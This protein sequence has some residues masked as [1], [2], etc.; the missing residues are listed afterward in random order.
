VTLLTPLLCALAVLVAGAGCGAFGYRLGAARAGALDGA[1]R[2]ATGA[3]PAAPVA[4]FLASLTEFGETVAPIWS[5]HVDASRQQMETAVGDLVGTFAGIVSLLDTVLASSRSALTGTQS[6]IFDTSRTRL[7]GVVSS[8]DATL[9]MKRKTLEELRL[10]RTLNEDMKTMTSEVTKI[11]S[12]THLLALNAAIEAERVGEAGRAFGVVAMEVR[13]LADLSGHTG[14]RIGQKAEEVRKALEA[15][16]TLAEAETRRE[17]EMVGAA[18]AQVHSVMDDLMSAVGSLRSSSTDLGR[19]AEEIKDQIARSLIDFQF[20][21]RICQTLEHLRDCIDLFPH[22]LAESI[23]GGPEAL[24]PFDSA[25][26][27]EALRNSYTMAEEHHV[28]ESGE[29]VAVRETEIT[30]F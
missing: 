11:A 21:D 29:T 8:L 22:V 2:G 14:E 6:E 20:Q 17:E 12:Q 23:D 30:F 1:G 10:L 13:Q 7:R 3:S 28:H 26:L 15:T 5:T 18:E 27:R 25:A 4:G 24:S 9:E 16:F 19:T